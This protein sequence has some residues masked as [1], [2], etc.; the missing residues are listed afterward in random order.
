MQAQ[1][2]SENKTAYKIYIHNGDVKKGGD[3]GRAWKPNIVPPSPF[4]E[5]EKTT[6]WH[7]VVQLLLHQYI[8]KTRFQ[9]FSRRELRGKCWNESSGNWIYW[10]QSNHKKQ[11][12]QGDGECV[13]AAPI[14][15]CRIFFRMEKK[16]LGQENSRINKATWDGGGAGVVVVVAIPPRR[17][18]Q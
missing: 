16:G 4:W 17:V 7:L 18:T 2:E 9:D 12:K 8:K 15:T 11:F 3:G 14:S 1:Q 5:R 13:L 6:V 10:R